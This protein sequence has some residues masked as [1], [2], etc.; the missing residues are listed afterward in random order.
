MKTDPLSLKNFFQSSGTDIALILS[1]FDNS[2]MKKIFVLLFALILCVFPS[3]AGNFKFVFADL[4]QHPE[5][6][7]GF[8]PTYIML[9][10]GYED[11][12]LEGNTT[13]IDLLVGGGYVQRKVFQNPETGEVPENEDEIRAWRES[14]KFLT[15]DV[16][17]TDYQ[18]RTYQGFLDDLLTL[19]F[20]IAMK[21]EINRDSFKS[22]KN[23]SVSS[24]LGSNYSGKIYPDLA[25]DAHAFTTAFNL[26]LTLNMM[27]DTLFEND[28]I[29]VYA[30]A[31]WAPYF[32][33][34]GI[35]DGFADYYSL[36]LNAV[37]AKTLW[38]VETDVNKW[39]SFVL[40]DRF[41]VNWTSGK[42]VPISAQGP[43]SLG[44]KVRGYSTYSYNSEFTLVNNLDLRV[45]GP[46][47][48]IASIM[49]RINIFLD[50]G[51]GSGDYFNTDLSASNFLG[52]VG[53][54]FTLSFFDMIDLGYQI[55][56]IFT[57]EKYTDKELDNFTT[58][59]TFFLDF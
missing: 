12:F 40:I 11:E 59:F 20:D 23:G 54:Q 38:S 28:G 57:G 35:T 1:F 47:L 24:F 19:R 42:H 13:E 17:Q 5:I 56:Y 18:I 7:A 10:A 30:E 31:K 48:G 41:N 33:Y 2:D 58:T 15:Y 43:V 9:G 22:G 25:G 21:Y 16:I 26:R 51:Y 8:L 53:A 44:R 32:L 39:V 50:L 29:E 52:S 36:T 55:A 6:L 46:A 14:G 49:P 34:H 3:F 45:A 4:N 37:F 27:E